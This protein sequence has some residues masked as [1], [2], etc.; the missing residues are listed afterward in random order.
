[1]RMAQERLEELLMEGLNDPVRIEVTKEWWEEFSEE[2]IQKHRMKQ[3]NNVSST[4]I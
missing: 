1:M 2:L 3:Q 4:T